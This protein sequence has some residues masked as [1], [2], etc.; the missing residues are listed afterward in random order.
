MRPEEYIE[1]IDYAQAW[2]MLHDPRKKVNP[3]TEGFALPAG[4]KYYLFPNMVS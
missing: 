4:K 2:V 3:M 1:D